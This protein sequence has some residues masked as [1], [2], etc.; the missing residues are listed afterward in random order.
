MSDLLTE[1]PQANA[2][3]DYTEFTNELLKEVEDNGK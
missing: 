3:T 1:A 2:T